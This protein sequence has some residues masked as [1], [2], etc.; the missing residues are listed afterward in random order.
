[1]ANGKAKGSGFERDLARRLSLWINGAEKP[2]VFWRTAG[3]GGLATIMAEN[4]DMSGDLM[5][6]RD[7]GRFLTNIFSIEAKCGYQDAEAFKHLKVNKSTEIED[8]WKQCCR[9]AERSHKY[10]LL[11]FKKKGY[12]T[13]I[14][15]SK[16]IGDMFP[17]SSKLGAPTLKSV[18]LLFPFKDGKR[19]LP[20]LYMYGFEDFLDMVGPDDMKKLEAMSAKT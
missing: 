12:P 13:I 18:A 6:I 10:P 2:Y 3:S 8:F 4:A 17:W 19:Y 5:A 1:M 11:I 20:D 9:D 15:F 14:G 7:E 16:T